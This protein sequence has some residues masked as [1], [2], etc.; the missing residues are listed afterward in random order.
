MLVPG[1][2][3]GILWDKDLRGFGVKIAKSGT[4]TYVYQY[5][6][7]GREAPTLRHT[8]GVHGLPW[9]PA[10]ARE[11]AERLSLHVARGN[12]PNAAEL[13]RRRLAVDLAFASYADRFR[14]TCGDSGWGKMVDR[15]LRL[16]VTPN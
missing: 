12:D 13:E 4:R 3:E 10:T 6:M 5:R 11:E 15:T 8:I 14:A 1:A 2:R 16:H 9:T 7:G